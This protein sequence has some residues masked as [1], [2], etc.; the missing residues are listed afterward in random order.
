M[1]TEK[2][3]RVFSLTNVAIKEMLDIY[4]ELNSDLKSTV[5]ANGVKDWED[6]DGSD[7]F[8]CANLQALKDKILS[9]TDELNDWHDKLSKI[10]VEDNVL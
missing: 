4:D 8:K 1:K 7:Y 3:S 6:I 9:L 10:K 5:I 2:L